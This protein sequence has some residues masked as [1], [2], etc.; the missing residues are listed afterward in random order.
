VGC[1][2]A[3]L[4][5]R[6]PIYWSNLDLPGAML[7][8]GVSTRHGNTWGQRGVAIRLAGGVSHQ[9]ED[10]AVDLPFACARDIPYYAVLLRMACVSW[11]RQILHEAAPNLQGRSSQNRRYQIGR[12]LTEHRHRCP[13]RPSQL[14]LSHLLNCQY[15]GEHIHMQIA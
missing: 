4:S 7:R 15:P 6:T 5:F 13:A 1:R 2:L 14:C 3:V 11:C 8:G 12:S 10:T 9:L